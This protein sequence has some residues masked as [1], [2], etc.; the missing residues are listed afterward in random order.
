MKNGFTIIEAMIIVIIIGILLAVAIPTIVRRNLQTECK[1][2]NS[3]S[4][5]K[6]KAAY[7]RQENK[8]ESASTIPS[9]GESSNNTVGMNTTCVSGHL[10]V[11]N[12][13]TATVFVKG[14][15]GK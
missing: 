3:T 8:A 1:R 7:D 14:C 9:I 6:L 2:G 11:Y 13:E 5:N 12:N 10:I 15:L 4:C